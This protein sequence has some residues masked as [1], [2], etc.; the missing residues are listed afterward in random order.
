M[1]RAMSAQPS[2][3][4]DLEERE[5]AAG[6][7][8]EPFRKLPAEEIHGEDGRCVEKDDHEEQ[9]ATE[10]G[11]GVQKCGD[12]FAQAG[13]HGEQAQDPQDAER[14]DDSP[15][16]GPG[17]E[18]DGDHD[19]VEDIPT[20]PP[21][22]SAEGEQLADDFDDEDGEAGFVDGDKQCA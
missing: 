6:E 20:A 17:H 13:D 2:K 15:R 16:S 9:H 22:E 11:N 12:H 21:E 19:E 7:R 14:T 10:S 8:A 5:K 1:S 4:R 3:V 18:G